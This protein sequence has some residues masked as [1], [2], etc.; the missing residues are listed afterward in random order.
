MAS[1]LPYLKRLEI[2]EVEESGT[3][4]TVNNYLPIKEIVE[5]V[6]QEGNPWEPVP[7]PDPWDDL[8]WVNKSSTSGSSILGSVLT[9]TPGTVTGGAP[10]VVVVSQW[11][12][13]ATTSGFAGFTP[14]EE[15]GSTPD[16]YTTTVTDNGMYVRLATKAT[17]ADGTVYYGS[18]NSIGPMTPV[19]I[20]TSQATKISNGSTVNPQEVFGFE[21]ISVI[22]AVFA[23]GF[24][25]LTQ[26]YRLQ[27]KV[28]GSDTW[29]NLTEW[30]A[31][32]SLSTYDVA[33]LTAGTLVRAQSRAT[34]E[35]GTVKTSSSPTPVVGITTSIGTVVITPDSAALAA[36][37]EQEFT[38]SVSGGSATNLMFNWT[39]RSGSAQLMSANN[40]SSTALYK[41]DTAGSTQIQ[42][43]VASPGASNTP[44]SAI[45]TIIVS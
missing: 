29:T 28:S 34:D 4:T 18:G 8:V 38:A 13:S 11:Q 5:V 30:N 31:S 7:G 12:R 21:T 43:Y 41:F 23:G 39:V 19:S 24:G 16:T 6:D 10:P 32:A 36:G 17:D 14:W 25:T 2:V 22:A 33:S 35:A 26:E 1:L 40:I 44:Q 9:G 42:C 37:I 20:T 45:A 27:K 15:L 3:P